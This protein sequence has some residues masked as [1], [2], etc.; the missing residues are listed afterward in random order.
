MLAPV[1]P[2]KLVSNAPKPS[3]NEFKKGVDFHLNFKIMPPETTYSDPIKLIKHK[4]SVIPCNKAE[5][6]FESVRFLISKR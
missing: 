5:T 6:L 1:V 4:K 2:S 3:N